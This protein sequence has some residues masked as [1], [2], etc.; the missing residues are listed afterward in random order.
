M[1]LKNR[2]RASRA[3]TGS[4]GN[5]TVYT[6]SARKSLFF[7][8]A[9]VAAP[10]STGLKLRLRL[11]IPKLTLRKATC[12]GTWNMAL[13]RRLTMPPE[14]KDPAGPGTHCQSLA[15]PRP[16]L[17][18]LASWIGT[19]QCTL[20][21]ALTP[22]SQWPQQ[23]AVS[24]PSKP[25]TEE[26]GKLLIHVRSGG[27]GPGRIYWVPSD[28]SHDSHCLVPLSS[29]VATHQNTQLHSVLPRDNPETIR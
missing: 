1:K 6:T 13:H 23:Q 9:V 5:C 26:L 4:Q 19:W 15:A 12:A 24:T 27:G 8:M 3:G 22:T 16:L 29:W 7:S 18:C 10:G 2:T 25:V 28:K 20:D 21:R 11:D 17:L 14:E